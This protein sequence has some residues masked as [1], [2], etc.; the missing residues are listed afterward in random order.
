MG[1]VFFPLVMLALAAPAKQPSAETLADFARF[2]KAVGR[3]IAIVDRDSLYQE[4][5]LTA[6]SHAAV[7]VRIGSSTTTFKRDAVMSAERLR[8]S[9]KDGVIKGALFGALLG[10]LASQG[11]TSEARANAGLRKSVAACAAIGWALD[12]AESNRVPIYRAPAPAPKLKLSL[13]F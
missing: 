3:E 4:G 10:A 2:S 11:Y 5:T 1:I 12:A 6:A 7:S 8:D 13:R 9:R